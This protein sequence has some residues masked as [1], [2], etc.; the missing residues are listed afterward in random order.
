MNAARRLVWNYRYFPYNYSYVMDKT[1]ISSYYIKFGLLGISRP[2]LIRL[3]TIFYMIHIMP[4]QKHLPLSVP[5]PWIF[6]FN[7]NIVIKGHN[8]TN[9]PCGS[10]LLLLRLQMKWKIYF[11]NRYLQPL[12]SASP[13]PFHIVYLCSWDI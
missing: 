11:Q 3:E 10:H 5:I 6:T 7:E 2:R 13:S 1:K 9:F 8:I 4:I 12:L